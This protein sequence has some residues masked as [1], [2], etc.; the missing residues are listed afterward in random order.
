VPYFPDPD[1]TGVIAA[2][3]ADWPTIRQSERIYLYAMAGLA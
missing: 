2:A 3:L 1:F